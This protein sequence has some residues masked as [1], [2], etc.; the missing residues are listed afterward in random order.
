[1]VNLIVTGKATSNVFDGTMELTGDGGE[2]VTCF[3][4]DAILNCIAYYILYE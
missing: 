4:V 3:I 2:K 1:M